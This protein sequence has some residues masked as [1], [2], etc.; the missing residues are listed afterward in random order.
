M[1]SRNFFCR[2]L[3]LFAAQSFL[4]GFSQV[5]SAAFVDED[6]GGEAALRFEPL[7]A[8]GCD[9]DCELE[10][11]D[12]KSS[13]GDT[14][15][16]QVEEDGSRSCILYLG[17]TGAFDFRYNL[18]KDEV[19]TL[20]VASV[21]EEK[22]VRGIREQ[23]E[24]SSL[25][26]YQKAVDELVRFLERKK[27]EDKKSY[28]VRIREGRIIHVTKQENDTRDC[29]FKAEDGRWL[30]YSSNPGDIDKLQLGQMETAIQNGIDEGKRPCELSAVIAYA[31]NLF[32]HVFN[33]YCLGHP[34]EHRRENRHTDYLQGL[35]H[36]P[37]QPCSRW[38]EQ[39]AAS[40]HSFCSSIK[41]VAKGPQEGGV[42]KQQSKPV[43]SAAKFAADEAGK[44]D[45]LARMFHEGIKN[46]V[47]ISSCL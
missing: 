9:R 1:S 24:P 25:D 32:A 26:G 35:P 23:M 21:I 22:L 45:P 2:F 17:D 16:V 20:E 46:R 15:S 19:E 37:G 41:P 11:Y 27:F 47:Q 28:T 5:Y 10:I 39:D 18:T 34:G 14:V 3:F 42:L 29:I 44:V 4:F 33:Q 7:L 31:S 8:G 6:S 40:D 36:P 13:S 38:R 12:L 30:K 43:V